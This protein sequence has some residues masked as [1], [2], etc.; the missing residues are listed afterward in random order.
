MWDTFRPLRLTPLWRSVDNP[1]Y[2]FSWNEER[3]ERFEAAPV[4]P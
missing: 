3:A 1:A 2:A 4:A